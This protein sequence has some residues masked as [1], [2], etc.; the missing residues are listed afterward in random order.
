MSTKRHLYSLA[1]NALGSERSMLD[2]E[3]FKMC[4]ADFFCCYRLEPQARRPSTRGPQGA[5]TATK[6]PIASMI[7]PAS[8]ARAAPRSHG[9]IHWP[10]PQLHTLLSGALTPRRVA[11]RVVMCIRNWPSPRKGLRQR[12]RARPPKPYSTT[13]RHDDYQVRLRSLTWVGCQRKH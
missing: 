5:S 10:H 2:V 6:T 11:R 12:Q 4:F 7:Q 13:L 9:H 3:K 8:L 1:P